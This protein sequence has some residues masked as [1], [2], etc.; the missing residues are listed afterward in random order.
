MGTMMDFILAVEELLDAIE[1]NMDK[2]NKIDFQYINGEF[3][4]VD[5]ELNNSEEIKKINDSFEMVMEL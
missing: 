3:N 2:D 5:Y 1:V 4:N